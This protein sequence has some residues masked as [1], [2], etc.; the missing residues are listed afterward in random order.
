MTSGAASSP[1]A[2]KQAKAALRQTILARRDAADVAN[3]NSNSQTI[4]QKLC[5]LPAYRAANVVAAYASFGSEL[6]T[7][8][9]LARVLRDGKQL[10]LPRI[11]HAQRALE[12]RHVIDLGADLVSGVWGIREPAERCPIMSVTN[13]ELM[14]VPGVAFTA[15]GARLGYGGGFYDRLLASLDRR[16][17]SIAAAFELQMVDHLPEGP[18]DQRVDQVVTEA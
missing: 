11:N 15:S 12:L 16:V 8:E 17:V 7:S 18:H 5:A 13:V 9:F 3:R 14:L 6:D 1:E 4:M 2:L 10:L